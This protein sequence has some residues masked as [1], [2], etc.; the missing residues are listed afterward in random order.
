MLRELVLLLEAPLGAEL[1]LRWRLAIDKTE[2][3]VD[4]S[5]NKGRE[6]VIVGL[7]VEDRIRRVLGAV[8]VLVVEV[9]AGPVGNTAKL[10]EVGERGEGDVD[11]EI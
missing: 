11:R 8:P 1:G 9:G 7:E 5:S 3:G 6:G 4:I 2:G 10:I